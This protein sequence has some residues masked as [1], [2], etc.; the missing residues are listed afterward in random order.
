MA[1]LGQALP[2]FARDDLS[3]PTE[4]GVTADRVTASEVPEKDEISSPTR[5]IGESQR[6]SLGVCD[7][8]WLAACWT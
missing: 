7:C 2:V 4:L 5:E 3:I 8:L 6:R 1:V